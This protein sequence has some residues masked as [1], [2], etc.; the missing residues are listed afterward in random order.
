MI[1]LDFYDKNK[2]NIDIY[3]YITGSLLGMLARFTS[4]LL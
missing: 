2:H 4:T 3:K 1:H